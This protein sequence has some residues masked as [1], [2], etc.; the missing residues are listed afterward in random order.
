M[1]PGRELIDWLER[2]PNESL[3]D[4][5]Y[6]LNCG[7]DHSNGGARVGLLA[8][9][10]TD[11]AERLATVVSRLHDPACRSAGDGRGVYHWDEPLGRSG[12]GTEAAGGRLAF[13]FPGEG[14]QYPGMLADLCFHFPIVRQQLDTSDRIALELGETEP[15]SEH[16][17]G[18]KTGD[19]VELWSSQT[20]VNVVLCSQRALYQVLTRLGLRPDA[21]AGHSCG[22]LLALAAA[23][24]LRTGPELERQLGRLGA[25]FRGFESTG[26]IPEARL[27]AVAAGKDRVEGIC[28]VLEAD[29]VAVAMDNC[30]HQVVLAGPPAQMDRVVRHLRSESILSEDLPFGRAYHTPSFAPILAPVVS[31]F[32][33]L[34]F[35]PPIL[36]V[37]SCATHGRMPSEPEAIRERAVAQ[38][39]RTVGFRE[40]I[41]AMYAD[42][43]RIFIDVGARGNLAG[44]AQDTLRGRPAFA[45][46]A[47]VPRRSGLTQLNHLV[48]ALFAQGV[49]LDAGFLYARRRP[50][51]V[52][53][54]A[55]TTTPRSTVE[56]ELGF[57][58]MSLSSTLIERLKTRVT[59]QPIESRLP[60]NPDET[61]RL[62]PGLQDRAAVVSRRES[63]VQAAFEEADRR[64][65]GPSYHGSNGVFP[66]HT[67][68]S[69]GSYPASNEL[70]PDAVMLKF[71]E[72][73]RAFLET[74]QEVLSAYLGVTTE[75]A[76]DTGN[77]D[78][79]AAGDPL[80]REPG[81]W[82][83]EV[84]QL[85]PGSEIET[86]YLLDSRSDPIAEN[87]TLGGRRISALDPSLKGLPVLP[88]AVM[89][90]MI[91]QAAALLV[92]PGWVL[93]GLQQIQA[94]KWVRYE[95]E[96]VYLE[97][98]GRCLEPGEIERVWV[99]IYNRGTAGQSESV[100]P[101]F[102]AV[103]LFQAARSDSPAATPWVLDA[104]RPSRFSAEWLYD[105]QWL[106][107]GPPFQA[108]VH[109]GSFSA[110]GD[111][112]IFACPALGA[113]AQTGPNSA[114]AHRPDRHRRLHATS[115]LLGPRLSH[116]R[117]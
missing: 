114:V 36:P 116:R 91:A 79:V 73:M 39:T 27:V 115:W 26:D 11:L 34:M 51:L 21:V 87:H 68:D 56:L 110:Q 76:A 43:L 85:V 16:L 47:N 32:D 33:Q 75:E 112:R 72:T 38:W 8:T 13:L 104:S 89:T 45:I 65:P 92:S 23:G 59:R 31:F 18:W 109:V 113:L 117:W 1:R 90:E 81:P 6:T 3:K 50:R 9:S 108:L 88:F 12:T 105:E 103:A 62:K 64:E 57:P 82:V 19:D 7:V 102:E 48:A 52:D 29:E 95:E 100:R 40:T 14:S 107:H 86:V 77:L 101:A 63:F 78:L 80:Q 4:V 67:A 97:L 61:D 24:V 35:S 44:F 70:E 111:R 28:R 69:N 46:A 60:G 42:G 71:Q 37:Y 53:W 55:T 5:A 15:P 41:E 54:N 20:A 94:H 74:Q 99:G 30:P 84:L 2:H 58:E 93:T 83:G 17:F 66:A 106:F 10:L 98:R 96:P 22:E 25:I 49:A